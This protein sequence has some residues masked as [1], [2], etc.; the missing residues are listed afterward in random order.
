[1]AQS[2]KQKVGFPKL[3]RDCKINFSKYARKFRKEIYCK[4]TF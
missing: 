2:Q 3:W 4:S 1:M